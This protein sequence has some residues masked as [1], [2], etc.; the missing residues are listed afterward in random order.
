MVCS[1]D[2][3]GEGEFKKKF[4]V[5]NLKKNSVKYLQIRMQIPF[6]ESG[7]VQTSELDDGDGTEDAVHREITWEQNFLHVS[8]S[9]SS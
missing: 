2:G 9:V 8:E 5:E 1:R 3:E 4:Y 6:I 7:G